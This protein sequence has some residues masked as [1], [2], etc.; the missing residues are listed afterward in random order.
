MEKLFDISL[1]NRK[2]LY[3]FLTETPREVLLKIPDGYR[4]NIWWNIAHV[5]VTQQLL[6]YQKSNLP[7][8]VES[9]LVDKFKKGSIP[10]GTATE[11]EIDKIKGYLFATAEWIQEDYEKGIFKE[12][13]AYTTTPKVVLNS[14]EDAIAF[15]VFHEGIHLGVI[16][17]L[18]KVLTFK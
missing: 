7:M 3:K 6:V 17:S 12:F 15:N 10:D 5:V 14:A 16:L 1:K 11:E 4:N 2:I 8:R 18:M 9:E 13:E